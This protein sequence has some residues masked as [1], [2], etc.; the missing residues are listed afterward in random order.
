MRLSQ[1]RKACVNAMMKDTIF[2]AASSVLEEHG[3]SGLTMNRVATTVGL[4][5]GSLYNYFQDKDD[6]LQFFCTRL[7]EPWMQAIEEI[8][9]AELPALQKLEKILHTAWKHAIEHKGLIR[10]LVEIDYD[11]KIRRDVRPR[12]LKLATAIFQQGIE[13][14]TL[15]QHNPTHTARMLLGCLSQLFELEAAGA[16]NEEVEEYVRLLIDMVLHG[17]SI[18]IEKQ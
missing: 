13:E 18:H 11:S 3:V 2:E 9:H 5:T 4:A 8:A 10:L 16:S 14:G 1:A 17:F 6:L 12:F 15:Q 7:V